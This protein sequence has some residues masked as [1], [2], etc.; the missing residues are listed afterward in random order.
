MGVNSGG[1]WMPQELVL[2]LVRQA[3]VLLAA[4]KECA[5][6]G[7][8]WCR[9][10]AHHPPFPFSPP[11][12][13]RTLPVS[14]SYSR[15]AAMP[16]SS[17]PPNTS[18]LLSAVMV[19]AAGTGSGKGKGRAKLEHGPGCSVDQAGVALLRETARDHAWQRARTPC[20]MSCQC[21]HAV[22]VRHAAAYTGNPNAHRSA[23]TT[24]L[25]RRGSCTGKCR[26]RRRPPPP[27]CGPGG[28]PGCPSCAPSCRCRPSSRWCCCGGLQRAGGALLRSEAGQGIGMG[29]AAG[30]KQAAQWDLIIQRPAQSTHVQATT[31]PRFIRLA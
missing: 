21:T 23:H 2:P 15:K 5:V 22:L 10:S 16:L 20:L 7:P 12:P 24:H 28:T 30:A 8:C 9:R 29:P 14:W 4:G 6:H 3:T 13:P 25:R 18:T 31:S 19:W 11:L 27:P 17:L 1:W 26:S